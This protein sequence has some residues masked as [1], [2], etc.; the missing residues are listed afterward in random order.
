MGW[1]AWRPWLAITF[2]AA[3]CTAVL[4]PAL[5]PSPPPVP[6][7]SGSTSFARQVVPILRQ[8]CA[9]C[10]VP[11]KPAPVLFEADGAPRYADARN[12]LDDMIR[13]VKKRSM[14]PAGQ[15]AMSADEIQV[16]EAWQ[17]AGAPDN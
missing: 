3:G 5:Y 17:K 6:I 15:P 13:V 9:A 12:R 11:D 4:P 10:H 8:H 1:P 7:A 16:L 2:A 14:P